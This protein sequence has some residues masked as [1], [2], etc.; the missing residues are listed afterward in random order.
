MNEIKG[1]HCNQCGAFLFKGE[2]HTCDESRLEKIALIARFLGER[3][4]DKAE[5]ITRG[6]VDEVLKRLEKI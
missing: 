3:H 4:H 1:Y 5:E 2:Q 6:Q